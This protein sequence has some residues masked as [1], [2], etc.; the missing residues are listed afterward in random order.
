MEQTGSGFMM[1]VFRFEQDTLNGYAPE[2]CIAVYA[3]HT[4]IADFIRIKVA[5]VTFS[6]SCAFPVI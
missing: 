5:S 4:V 2:F 3:F 1:V 6:A